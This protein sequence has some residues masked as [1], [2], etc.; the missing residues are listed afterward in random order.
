MV[1]DTELRGCQGKEIVLRCTLDS[2][3]DVFS[4]TAINSHAIVC[5]IFFFLYLPSAHMVCLTIVNM[6]QRL[7]Q[8]IF[9]WNLELGVEVAKCRAFQLAK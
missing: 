7:S 8:V 9:S 4:I 2:V 5:A 1:K 3:C 6:A